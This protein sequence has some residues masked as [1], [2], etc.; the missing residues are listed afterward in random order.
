[1]G[2]KAVA[3][4]IN[5]QWMAIKRSFYGCVTNGWTRNY[6]ETGSIESEHGTDCSKMIDNGIFDDLARSGW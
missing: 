6:H 4:Q 1:M 2:C 3:H 5:C